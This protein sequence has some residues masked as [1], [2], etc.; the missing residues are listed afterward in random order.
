MTICDQIRRERGVEMTRCGVIDGCMTVPQVARAFGLADDSSIYR[1]IGREE[2]DAIAH[3]LL[4]TG[5]AYDS[6]IMS[7]ACATDLWQ[8]FLAAFEGQ[9]IG[10]VTNML[11]DSSWQPATAS[12]FDM[13][14]LV[15]GSARVGCLWVE[16]ED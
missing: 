14:V 2:A 8:Q 16:E 7:P 13:G 12:T 10:F 11:S 1:P 3:R 5:L 4:S 15:V 6:A 9:D